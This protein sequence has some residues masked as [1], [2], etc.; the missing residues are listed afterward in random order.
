MAT[1]GG[2]YCNYLIKVKWVI[3]LS[4]PLYLAFS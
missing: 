3:K 1:S 2:H 4:I